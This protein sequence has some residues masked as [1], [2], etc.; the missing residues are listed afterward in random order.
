[1]EIFTK[2]FGRTRNK[3]SK[4]K[5]SIFNSIFFGEKKINENEKLFQ[6]ATTSYLHNDIAN[7]LK[8]IDT[9]L[10]SGST[11]KW[12]YFAFRANCLEEKREYKKAIEDYEV[13]I[14]L[15]VYDENVYALYHQIGFCYLNLNNNEKA[16]EFYT[17]ALQLKNHLKN[18]GKE[19][20]EGLDGGVLIGVPFKRIHNN[21]GNALKN[22]NRFDDAITDCEKAIE[23]DENYSNPYLLLSQI[24]SLKGNEEESIENLE[25]SAI[26][27]NRYA[28]KTIANLISDGRLTEKNTKSF[29]DKFS[30]FSDKNSMI[31]LIELLNSK[32]TESAYANYHLKTYLSLIEFSAISLRN[33]NAL[34]VLKLLGGQ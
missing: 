2:A 19:D 26:L 25:F 3:L 11:E 18:K 13:A 7:A 12:E 24:Y 14:E 10:K 29:F 23:Y 32:R 9:C 21:R 22:L 15:N 16:V 27:G 20:L 17:Y 4:S 33:E 6:V 8:N 34:S 28:I 31:F 1:M 5:K 30:R